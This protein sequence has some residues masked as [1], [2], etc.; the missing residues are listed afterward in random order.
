MNHLLSQSET[1]F[2]EAHIEG[3][4]TDHAWDLGRVEQDI[5]VAGV[6]DSWNSMTSKGPQY[7]IKLV[8]TAPQLFLPL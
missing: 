4:R 6:E 1:T 2:R 7:C 8:T 5:E 3:R